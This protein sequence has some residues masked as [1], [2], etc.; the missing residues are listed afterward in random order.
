MKRKLD[1]TLT[2]WLLYLARVGD[3]RW[4][5]FLLLQRLSSRFRDLLKGWNTLENNFWIKTQRAQ[6]SAPWPNALSLSRLRFSFFVLCS[7]NE[8]WWLISWSLFGSTLMPTSWSHAPLMAWF[9]PLTLHF[10]FSNL[11]STTFGQ[12]HLLVSPF[13]FLFNCLQDNCMCGEWFI[14]HPLSIVIMPRWMSNI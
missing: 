14:H 13:F 9:I 11:F 12:P 10:K 1:L 6:K 5:W 4:K 7:W 2:T 3:L 8:L